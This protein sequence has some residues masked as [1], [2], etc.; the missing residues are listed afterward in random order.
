MHQPNELSIMA[1]FEPA[2]HSDIVM[3]NSSTGRLKELGSSVQEGKKAKNRVWVF[4]VSVR[5]LKKRKCLKYVVVENLRQRD[6][7]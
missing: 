3:R 4:E 5:C 1:R 6:G 7:N 2:V